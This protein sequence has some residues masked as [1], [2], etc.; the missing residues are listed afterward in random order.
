MSTISTGIVLADIIG[1][2]TLS[3]AQQ[4]EALNSLKSVVRGGLLPVYAASSGLRVQEMVL[5]FVPTGD[6]FYWVLNVGLEPWAPLLALGLRSAGVLVSKAL[7]AKGIQVQ[8]RVAAHCGEVAEISD[9]ADHPNFVGDGM[10]DC[11][12]LLHATQEQK[13]AMEAFSGGP[14]YVVASRVALAKLMG[15][16]GADP[17]RWLA[18]IQWREGP[19][20]IIEDKHGKQH[21]ARAIDASR[22]VSIAPPRVQ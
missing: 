20:V 4:V 11:A 6:G 5:G 1:Y 22:F 8:L 19:D 9:I 12:R 3:T 10:N 7:R 13:R 15:S 18:D 21:P 2:S 14:D 17:V 16:L